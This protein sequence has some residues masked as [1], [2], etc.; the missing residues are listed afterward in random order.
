MTIVGCRKV[1]GEEQFRVL[2]S[3]GK[4][5]R[6]GGLCWFTS[7]YIAWSRTSDLT[8]ISGWNRVK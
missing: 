4:N 6:D 8:I 1:N 5:W 2:N 7:N 3:W